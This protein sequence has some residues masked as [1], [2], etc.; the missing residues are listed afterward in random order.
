[1][2]TS[3]AHTLK[4]IVTSC[5][6]LCA[7]AARADG[8]YHIP[9]YTGTPLM[10][11]AGVITQQNLNSALR[12]TTPGGGGARP[13]TRQGPAYLVVGTTPAGMPARMAALL[14]PASRAAAQRSYQEMLDRHP[15]LMKQ[16]GVRSDDVACGVATFLAGSYMAYRDIDFPDHQFKPLYEQ[17]RGMIAANP[18][19]AEA[20]MTARREMFEQMAIIGTFLALSH[21]ALKQRPDLKASAD[22]KLAAKGYLEQFMK[23]D[24]DRLRLT[25]QGMTLQ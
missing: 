4:T 1:M 23:L 7:V 21:D 22:M 6:V 20:N 3:S 19:F 12:R 25:D 16:L 5:A 10:I 13:D 2:R 14:P 9:Q 18:K 24:A 17:V 15:Q 11:T 8:P